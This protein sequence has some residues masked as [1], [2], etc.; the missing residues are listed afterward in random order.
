MCLDT[1]KFGKGEQLS[2]N[3]QLNWEFHEIYLYLVKIAYCMDGKHSVLFLLHD[4]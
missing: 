2:W 1:L 4:L 3:D